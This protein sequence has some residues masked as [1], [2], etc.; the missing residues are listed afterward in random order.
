MLVAGIYDLDYLTNSQSPL[1][2][3][4]TFDGSV[5]V[6]A[7]SGTEDMRFPVSVGQE[8]VQI[9]IDNGVDAEFV[10]VTGAGHYYDANLTPGVDAAIADILLRLTANASMAGVNRS[11]QQGDTDL[12]TGNGTAV[13][14][15]T[16]S[17][18]S[19]TVGEHSVA[20]GQTA[21]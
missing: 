15:R 20:V 19:L 17:G 13:V 3:T 10:A 12:L 7:I 8:Y 6:L 1:D 11:F 14:R 5:K 16:A 18:W 9:L 4:D 2:F 21:T